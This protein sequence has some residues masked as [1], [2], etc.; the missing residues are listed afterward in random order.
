MPIIPM[1]IFIPSDGDPTDLWVPEP[2]AVITLGGL[3]LALMGLIVVMAAIIAEFVFDREIDIL[4]RIG[5]AVLLSGAGSALIGV[6]L[7]LITGHP[8]T[9]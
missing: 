5:M 2:V 3:V 1:P 7:A 6:I 9:E 8:A 4:F